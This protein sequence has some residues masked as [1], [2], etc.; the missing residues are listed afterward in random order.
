MSIPISA[1]NVH[2][3]VRLMPGIAINNSAAH[4]MG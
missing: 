1:I 3:A 4:R 2:A